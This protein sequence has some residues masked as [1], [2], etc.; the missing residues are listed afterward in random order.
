[1]GFGSPA[2][3]VGGKVVGKNRPTGLSRFTSGIMPY[4]LLGLTDFD[5][6]NLLVKTPEMVLVDD[7][8]TMSCQ[9]NLK[10][11]CNKEIKIKKRQVK[12]H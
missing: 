4:E 1:M 3:V 8:K 7:L 10:F 6:G 2:E 11:Y 12:I 5:Q 9:K